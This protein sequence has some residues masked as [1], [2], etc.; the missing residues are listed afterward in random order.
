M[1]KRKKTAKIFGYGILYQVVTM[2][3]GIVI[4]KLLI[5]SYGSEVN[6]L[7]SSVRQVF[8]YVALLEAGIG[9][10]SLQAL[11]EPIVAGNHERVSQIMAATDRYYKRTGFIYGAAIVLLAILYPI[12]VQSEIETPIIIAVIIFQ[13]ASGVINYFFQGK[14][15]I[16]LRADGKSYITINA[17]T[18]VS[19]VTKLTQI[20]L[21]LQGFNVV[22]VQIAH[23]SINLCQ[24]CY[25]TWYVRKNYSWLDLSVNPDYQA[26]SQSKNVIV[27]QISRL[28]F[29]NTDII[30]LTL[31]CGLKIVSVYSLYNLIVTCVS[32]VIDALGNSVEFVLGQSYNSDKE[33]FLKI[34]EI[35]E[36]YYLGVSFA[37]FTVA[38]VMLPS[39][40][41]VYTSG[42]TDTNYIDY[43]LPFLF[44]AI[45][46]LLY[47][48]R[49]SN[50]IIY[51]AGHF[52]Q[53]QWRSVLE[54]I[55][56]LTVSLSLV[57]YIGIYGVLIGTIV[58][59]LYRTND[60]IVYA[61]RV[62]LGRS[63]VNTYRRWGQ[64]LII[65]ILCYGIFRSMLPEINGYL[66]WIMYAIPVFCA[67]CCTFFFIDSFA[68]R[69]SYLYI[70][71]LVIGFINKY[72][73]NNE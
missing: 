60:V 39:F 4:P 14:Y 17:T 45:N 28:I 30:V 48:R 59:S 23:F 33:Y 56:N 24:M 40:I 38:L 2:F 61:N 20:V 13:G 9:T 67:C 58:A 3:L 54:S 31:F 7:L 32:N 10:A 21:I 42:I 68:D 15:A 16:L 51:I 46:I 49:T 25:I 73:N 57:T 70:K 29:N 47:A 64:N 52:K 34:Q 69:E 41:K 8:V 44:I 5:V 50:Q 63:P 1:S 37:F 18:I 65:M 43:Y 62:I 27:H 35:Y 11:Y 6:G 71:H 22:A 66:E 53:T 72:T 55:I 26:L 12:V 19:V 36:T